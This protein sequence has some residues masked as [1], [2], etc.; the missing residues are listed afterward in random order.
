MPVTLVHDC[1]HCRS[2]YVGMTYVAMS[3]HSGGRR[4]TVVFRCNACQ[5]LLCAKLL[6]INSAS[7]FE[8]L[9]RMDGELSEMR[10]DFGFEIL[11]TYPTQEAASAPASVP[12]SVERAFLQGAQNAAVKNSDAAAAM[13]RK[14]IDIATR[15]LDGSLAGK[16][17]APRIDALHKAGKLTEDLKEWA[18]LIRLDGNQGAHD[19]DELSEDQIQQLQSFTE[20]FL[21]YTFTLPAEVAAKKGLIAAPGAP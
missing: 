8:W 18:H 17:L 12:A 9:N 15:E 20:L 5:E 6:A 16:N 11:G 19:D 14:A 2:N 10:G 21:T 7:T 4:S 3:R 1:P 13:F